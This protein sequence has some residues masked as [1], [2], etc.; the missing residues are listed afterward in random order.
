M[1]GKHDCWWPAGLSYWKRGLHSNVNSQQPKNCGN[2]GHSALQAVVTVQS[3]FLIGLCPGDPMVILLSGPGV[4]HPTSHGYHYEKFVGRYNSGLWMLVMQLVT[5]SSLRAQIKS[6]DGLLGH[7]GESS[8]SGC[9]LIE[10]PSFHLFRAV[11]R[12]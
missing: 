6:Y 5:R 7:P 2:H 1:A 4:G 9:C 10:S 8:P 11:T 3:E 12:L